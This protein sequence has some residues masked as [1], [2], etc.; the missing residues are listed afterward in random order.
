MLAGALLSR[1][2][3]QRIEDWTALVGQIYAGNLQQRLPVIAHD[4]P[5]DKLSA[6]INGML[7][8]IEQ[9]VGQLANVGN[10][11][12][13]D[14]RTP[15]TRVR[16]T[17]ERARENA[18]TVEELRGATDRAINGL[19]QSLNVITAL[20]RIAAIEHGRRTTGFADIDLAEIAGTA[21]ELY[22]PFADNRHVQ[23][24]TD[25]RS[26][27]PIVGDRDLL[28]EA[29]ANLIDNAIKFTPEGGK[30]SVAVFRNS[31]DV[32]L[33]VSDTG[34]GIGEAE[35][36]AVTRRFYRADKSRR[37]PGAGLGLS[38]V[39]AIVKLHGFR[40]DIRGG[41]GC[42]IEIACPLP[43]AGGA[44]GKRNQSVAE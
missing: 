38:L 12:A 11:I 42:I 21:V 33:Q 2:A 39:A 19:D 16:A 1:G 40:L 25:F 26:A 7:D 20:L 14:L 24:D 36:E 41:P 32:V 5:F 23:L 30:V 17:L 3:R 10:D 13:H 8:H 22:D 29:A 34:P 43:V 6:I 27:L 35:R 44:D 15:L 31:N 37:A 28:F 9:L 4:E 18:Q